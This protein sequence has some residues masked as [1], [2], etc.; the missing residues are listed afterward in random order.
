MLKIDHFPLKFLLKLARFGLRSTR[1]SFGQILE[2]DLHVKSRSS[3][4]AK[5]FKV[6]TAS[7]KGF[8]ILSKMEKG[9]RI[10]S[11]RTKGFKV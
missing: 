2:F 9:F 11:E 7:A 3:H 1:R 4:K 10:E 8:K 6:E 5:G